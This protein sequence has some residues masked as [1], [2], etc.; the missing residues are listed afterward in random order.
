MADRA[1]HGGVPTSGDVHKL[2]E[3][4]GVPTAGDKFAH[5]QIEQVLG[6]ERTA[7]RYR[8]VTD[9]WR[10]HLL[11]RNNV[12]LAAEPGVGFLAMDAEQRITAGLRGVKSGA[13]KVLRSVKRADRAQTEDPVLQ[14]VQQHL[15]RLGAAVLAESTHT[16]KQ[17]ELTRPAQQQP[18]VVPK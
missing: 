18:R 14:G 3:A 16:A 10:A 17:I 13:R 1:F 12:D 8:T 5:E 6:I 15:R 7:S 4:F 9:A 2:L 11:N